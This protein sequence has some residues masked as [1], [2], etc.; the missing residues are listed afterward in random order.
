MG[1]HRSSCCRRARQATAAGA[2]GHRRRPVRADE[3][4]AEGDDGWDGLRGRHQAAQPGRQVGSR[5]Q[6][7][8]RSA[9]A[10]GEHPRG[11]V[12]AGEGPRRVDV[13]GSAHP[14][15]R[16]RSS[17]AGRSRRSASTGRPIGVGAMRSAPPRP[18]SPAGQLMSSGPSSQFRGRFRM[19]RL[20]Y[21]A[22]IVDRPGWDHHRIRRGRSLRPVHDR[23]PA[24]FSAAGTRAP[25]DGCSRSCF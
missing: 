9:A 4:I 19:S 14:T 23:P 20:A 24:S 22:D 11:A 6:H 2:A 3:M 15:R 10:A 12:V 16:S 1:C 17:S 5:R 13:P 18:W 8:R 25:A 21:L 7:H